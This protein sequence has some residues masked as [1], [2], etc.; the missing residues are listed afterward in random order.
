[1]IEFC[2][3]MIIIGVVLFVIATA[4]QGLQSNA[5]VDTN[6]RHHINDYTKELEFR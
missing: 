4:A 6:V 2:R 5:N 3:L 1:M